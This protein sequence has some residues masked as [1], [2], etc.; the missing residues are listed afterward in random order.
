MR[1]GENDDFARPRQPAA[2]ELF[3]PLAEP[4]PD[5]RRVQAQA[6]LDGGRDLV[7]VLTA[8]PRRPHRTSN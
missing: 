3:E 4:S 5:A 8:R 1:V 2:R 7:D 6:A